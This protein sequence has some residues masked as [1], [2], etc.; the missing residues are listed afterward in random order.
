MKLA[1]GVVGWCALIAFFFWTYRL[2]RRLSFS[3]GDFR[4]SSEELEL[5]DD[6]EGVGDG[7]VSVLFIAVLRLVGD[8]AELGVRAEYALA[9]G[10]TGSDEI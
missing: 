6:G 1:L 9:A 7:A 10:T 8:S 3:E 4:S 2:R 5:E